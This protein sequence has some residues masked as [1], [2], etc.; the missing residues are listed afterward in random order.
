[1]FLIELKNINKNKIKVLEEQLLIKRKYNEIYLENIY[2]SCPHIKYTKECWN[3]YH[4]NHT[5]KV[6]DL[7]NLELNWGDGK[8]ETKYVNIDY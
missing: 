4:H 8:I 2:I 5:R 7:C 6:C 3:D 1:M